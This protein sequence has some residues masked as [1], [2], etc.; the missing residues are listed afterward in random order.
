MVMKRRFQ[1]IGVLLLIA[2][3]LG[4]GGDGDAPKPE[5]SFVPTSSYE[6]RTVEGWTVHVNRRLLNEDAALGTA[7]LRLL[8]VKLYDITRVVP[9]K[10]LDELRK[11]PI[12]LG[13]DDGSAPCAEY[14]PSK[15]WLADHGYNP[16]KA[17]CVEIGNAAKFLQWSKDQ[18]AMV[19]HELAHSY[20]DRVLGFDHP[21]VKDAYKKA[22][23]GKQY[24]AALHNNGRETRSYALTDPQEYFAEGS[25]AFFG[26]ND[27]Y[28]F[29][30]AELRRHD[31]GLERLLGEVW[32]R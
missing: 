8:E 2:A 5:A 3:S 15:Q 12:W 21:A 30:R 16:D 9:S 11:V 10:A 29:V 23:E 28:P 19:L 31:A 20:H 13:V 26:T 24:E 1:A 22:V 18:P 4:L 32:G 7:A 17:K 6:L 27:M 25:E 14:H